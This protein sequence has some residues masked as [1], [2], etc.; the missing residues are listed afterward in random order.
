MTIFRKGGERE[1]NI[2]MIKNVVVG[3]D[4]KHPQKFN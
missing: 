2:M 1:D 4:N 3:R